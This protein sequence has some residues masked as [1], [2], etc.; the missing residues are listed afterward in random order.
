MGATFFWWSVCWYRNLFPIEY[1][2]ARTPSLPSKE[3]NSFFE[4]GVHH[5]TQV[6]VPHEVWEVS[7]FCIIWKKVLLDLK[8]S[9]HWLCRIL[10]RIQNNP[11][12]CVMLCSLVS[13]YQCFRGAY[14]FHLHCKRVSSM[15][16]SRSL[17][18]LWN[19][20]IL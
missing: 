16:L 4:S 18:Q 12:W 3:I 20:A 5:M 11:L 7:Q 8:F 9:W 2:Y 1:T 17:T 15:E 13:I 10:H 19:I 6:S 14:C